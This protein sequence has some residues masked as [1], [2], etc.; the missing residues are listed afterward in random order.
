ME[1]VVVRREAQGYWLDPTAYTTLLPSIRDQLPPG[2]RSFAEAPGHYDF[3]ST[4]CVKDL[5][6][7]SLSIGRD[8]SAAVSFAPYQWKHDV[9]LTLEYKS[10]HD[11]TLEQ[12]TEHTE[13]P[14]GR[15]GAVLLDE[16][17]PSHFGFVH[18][19]VLT[20][21]V[22][23]VRTL[24]TVVMACKRLMLDED[25]ALRGRVERARRTDDDNLERWF[26]DW[27]VHHDEVMHEGLPSQ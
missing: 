5:R 12:Q 1:H 17:L 8:G 16:L 27:R 23:R 26:P 19:V 14:E 3:D 15:F 21:S 25:M 11:V 20:N 10:V 18:E 7:E 13:S 9:G 24:N 6:F 22:L 4:Q 2:A